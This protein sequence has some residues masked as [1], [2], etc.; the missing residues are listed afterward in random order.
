MEYQPTDPIVDAVYLKRETCDLTLHVTLDLGPSGSLICIKPASELTLHSVINNRLDS[1]CPACQC[2]LSINIVVHEDSNK[3]FK[4]NPKPE[5]VVKTEVM[6]VA[7]PFNT[8]SPP[9]FDDNSSGSSESGDNFRPSASESDEEEITKKGKRKKKSKKEK[10]LKKSSSDTKPKYKKY[11]VIKDRIKFCMY[12]FEV[13]PT[14]AEH[15][16][17][18]RNHEAV[19]RR[20]DPPVFFNRLIRL[21][22]HSRNHHFELHPMYNET[23]ICPHC[24]ER[25]RYSTYEMHMRTCG[26]LVCEFCNKTFTKRATLRKHRRNIHIEGYGNEHTCE[27]CGKVFPRKNDFDRH[28]LN[29][30]ADTRPFKCDLCPNISYRAKASIRNHIEVFHLKKIDAYATC[31]EC[32]LKMKYQYLKQHVKRLH[33]QG[34]IFKCNQC[35]KSFAYKKFLEE[36][37]LIHTD[38]RPFP[39]EVCDQR[40]RQK[41]GLVSHMRLHTGKGP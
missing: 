36:H 8:E 19:C 3:S 37:Q 33:V 13:I 32:G 22:H 34:K 23:K 28:Y 21:R 20:C 24:N 15:K 9:F 41:A 27:V 14:R 39:C 4:L 29:H 12:C 25:F 6:E 40:F 1:E 38:I 35:D 5:S 17:H 18:L 30:Q 2:L 10:G 7:P 16:E 11:P 26:P 31:T